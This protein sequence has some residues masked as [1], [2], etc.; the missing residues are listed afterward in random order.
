MLFPKS[1]VLNI[2]NTYQVLHNG[3][4]NYFLGPEIMVVLDD[5]SVI[6]TKKYTVDLLVLIEYQHVI[7]P[8]PIIRP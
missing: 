1:R 3:G 4:I 8:E 7:E 5:C 2:S 6:K